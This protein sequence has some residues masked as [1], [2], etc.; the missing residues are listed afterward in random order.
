[1]SQVLPVD[2]Q[3][4]SSEVVASDLPVVGDFYADWCPPCRMLAPILDRLASEF[5]GQIK[6]VKV[7]SDAEPELAER[8]QVTGFPRW[9]CLREAAS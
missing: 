4:F 8:Y 3:Q 9:S 7:N 1:M 2:Q 6:F 5:A